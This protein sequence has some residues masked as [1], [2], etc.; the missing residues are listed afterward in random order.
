MT[1]DRSI[2]RTPGFPRIALRRDLTRNRC[3]ESRSFAA[4]ARRGL[5]FTLVELAIAVAVLSIVAVVAI[6][7]LPQARISA[8]E[9]SAIGTLKTITVSGGHYRARFGSFPTSLSDLVNAGYIDSGGSS[10]FKAGYTF[11]YTRSSDEHFEATAQPTRPGETGIRYFF[12]DDSGVIR[13]SKLG[14]AGGG[15][16]RL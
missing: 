10:P 8:N 15:S 2:L 16:P 12:V 7:G 13:F 3:E 14:P 11:T 6:P 9:R 1:H 4:S 5:A